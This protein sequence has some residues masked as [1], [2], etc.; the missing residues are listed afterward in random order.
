MHIQNIISIYRAIILEPGAFG[1]R[2]V[3]NDA[4]ISAFIDDSGNQKTAMTGGT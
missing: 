3:R 2:Q 4:L 1:I